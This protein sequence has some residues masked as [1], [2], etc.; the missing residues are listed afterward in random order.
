[1]HRRY[2][3]TTTSLP[4][5]TMCPR[6]YN[7]SH[8]FYLSY[9]ECNI[10]GINRQS[11]VILVDEKPSY[12][13]NPLRIIIWRSYR[14]VCLWKPNLESLVTFDLN[15]EWLLT[16]NNTDKE[17][18]F[19]EISARKTSPGHGCKHTDRG[20][21]GISGRIELIFRTSNRTRFDRL[22]YLTD[23]RC[24]PPLWSRTRVLRRW[25]MVIGTSR[26]CRLA[27]RYQ[28]VF[29][30]NHS[31][32]ILRCSTRKQIPLCLPSYALSHDHHVHQ[33]GIFWSLDH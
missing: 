27:K 22:D 2:N 9:G 25:I 12:V 31:K 21:V 7:W 4:V 3:S 20:F 10:G 30:L 14:Y 23:D 13:T 26:C 6:I 15:N 29:F 18:N 33:G 11:D 28:M 17:A 16:I 1:M 19:I 32:I 24:F 8:T 5:S